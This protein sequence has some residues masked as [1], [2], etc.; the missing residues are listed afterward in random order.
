[1]DVLLSESRDIVGGGYGFHDG[2]IGEVGDRDRIGVLQEM[3]K[4]LFVCVGNSGRSQMAEA[5][6]RRLGAGVVEAQ[7]AGTHPA[8]EISPMVRQVMA[9]IGYD[10]AGQRPKLVSLDMMKSADRVISMGCG[11]N[12]EA[13]CP[14][15]LVPTEDWGIQDPDGKPLEDVL[16]IRDTIRVRVERLVG[17]MKEER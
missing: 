8:S 6:A 10:M 4:V 12:T 3:K 15:A 2:S 7:S 11:V 13:V 5:F 14:A 16:E 9:E 17:E 1:M